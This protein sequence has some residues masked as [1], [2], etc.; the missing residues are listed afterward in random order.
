MK[1][2]ISREIVSERAPVCSKGLI[3]KAVKLAT[4]LDECEVGVFIVTDASREGREFAITRSEHSVHGNGGGDTDEERV[5]NLVAELREGVDQERKLAERAV[6][7][8]REQATIATRAAKEAEGTA[9]LFAEA[10]A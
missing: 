2:W 8:W 6:N 10:L 7:H 9:A 1:K 5:R 4:A 3:A